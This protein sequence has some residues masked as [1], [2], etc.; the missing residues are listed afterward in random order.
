MPANTKSVMTVHTLSECVFCPRAGVIAQELSQNDE[1]DEPPQRFNLDYAPPFHL[2]GIEEALGRLTS[3]VAKWGVVGGVTLVLAMLCWLLGYRLILIPL[4]VLLMVVSWVTSKRVNRIAELS[5]WREAARS[6]SPKE[7]APTEQR[8]QKVNWWEMLSAGFE[9]ITSREAYVDS[10]L[11]LA[12]RPW[13]VL[14]KGSLRIPVIKLK[15]TEERNDPQPQHA[16]RIAAYCR[17]LKLNEGM[18]SPYAILL[19][20]DSWDGLAVANSD[21]LQHLLKEAVK[22]ARE[23]IADPECL[24]TPSRQPQC[25]GCEFGRPV[26]YHVER[27]SPWWDDNG[28]VQG[29]PLGNKV[30]HSCCGDRFG[31]TP[32]H[33]QAV[34]LKLT[35]RG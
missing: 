18:E 21:A 12:G 15:S 2:P 9:S 23:V 4:G 24:G 32:P 3:N 35:S 25:K 10:E 20:G 8:H 7:P 22:F 30:F 19:F 26:V 29:V 28:K 6:A 31:W 17:L 1:I 33:E 34:K 16:V 14:R 27:G 5:E 13:R 11:G